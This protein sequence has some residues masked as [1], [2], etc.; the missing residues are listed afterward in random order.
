MPAR[1][2]SRPG[3]TKW[4]VLSLLALTLPLAGTAL[5][6]KTAWSSSGSAKTVR[7][8][9]RHE[10]PHGTYSYSS[11][12]AEDGPREVD[13]YTFS[14]EH[15]HWRNTSGSQR[16]WDEVE[17][18]LDRNDG[19]LFWFRRGDDRYLVTD[20]AAL[21]ELAEVFKPQEDL[22]RK[23]GELG[24]KQ[25]ELGRLQGQLGRRQ[26]ELGR[27][28]ARLSQAQTRLMLR[29]AASDRSGR[30]D[31]EFEQALDEI[32]RQQEEAGELQG[33][34]GGQQNALGE[35]QSAL[36]EQQAALGREQ[37]RVGRE[38]AEALDRITRRLITDG[39]AE[40]LGR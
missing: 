22:G 37:A 40:H 4:M 28:Q 2:G 6:G 12:D 36:G 17:R 30:Q 34:L 31:R 35:R 19:D 16:D 26:G 7:S 21:A 9:T 27:I 5:A 20:P 23:Q 3:A 14:R 10:T 15:G 11:S 1:S 33:E 39:R 25:G 13:A 8:E 18:L 32:R 24:R 29:Q 38:V